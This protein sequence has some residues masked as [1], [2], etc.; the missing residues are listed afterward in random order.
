MYSSN[1]NIWIIFMRLFCLSSSD[2]LDIYVFSDI[3]S[4]FSNC[5]FAQLIVLMAVKKLLNLT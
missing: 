2:V 5:L 3:F 4:L 1:P